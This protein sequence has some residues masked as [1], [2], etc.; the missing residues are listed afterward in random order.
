M[1]DNEQCHPWQQPG[2]SGGTSVRLMPRHGEG[3]HKLGRFG[4]HETFALCG[5]NK[6]L[7]VQACEE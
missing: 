4:S 6:G 2:R 5:A 3:R 1:F 7:M